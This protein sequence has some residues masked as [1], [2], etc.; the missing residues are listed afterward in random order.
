M[1]PQT[2]RP[3]WP[4]LTMEAMQPD[5]LPRVLGAMGFDRYCGTIPRGDIVWWR[6]AY[7]TVPADL[8]SAY[9]E[10][11]PVYLAS[12]RNASSA[13]NRALR[14]SPVH[15]LATGQRLVL[16]DEFAGE[17]EWRTAD[18]ANRGRDLID[19]GMWRWSCKFGQAAGRIQ[20][21][22]GMQSVPSVKVAA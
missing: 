3:Y 20:K 11:A 10:R 17:G 22:I 5:N 16:V 8:F 1:K 4:S 2:S 7:V 15:L 12:R 13:I 18:G 19:L 21:L 6:P 14:D 9:G